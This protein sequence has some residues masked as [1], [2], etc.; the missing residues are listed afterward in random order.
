[1]F[2]LKFYTGLF[3][4]FRSLVLRRK[5]EIT[6]QCKGCGRCCENILLKDGGRWLTS[7]RKFR[8]LCERE[9]E[10]ARFDI[11]GKDDTGP[12]V[13]SCSKLGD[14]NFCTC[15]E[16]RLP[17]CKN[18]PSKSLYYQGDW[19]RADC[20]FSFKVT[21]FRDIYMRRKRSE[22]PPFSEVLHQKIEQEK[23]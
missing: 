5:V 4:R 1:M 17:L 22:I 13:F 20:G 23:K 14:D 9:P 15:Y 3:R 6:G 2:S 12:L 7:K 16:S 10:H 8:K 11:V 18:Y 21:T 19:L